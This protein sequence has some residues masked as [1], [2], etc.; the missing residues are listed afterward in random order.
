MADS[1]TIYAL[2]EEGRVVYVGR[3][4]HTAQVRWKAH[5]NP[6]SGKFAGRNV[7]PLT[8][9][10]NLSLPQANHAEREL[11]HRGRKRGWP[12]E[13]RSPGGTGVHTTRQVPLSRYGK[14]RKSAKRAVKRVSASGTVFHEV[15]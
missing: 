3:T 14:S 13:N 8:L 4:R 1:F 12:L 11:I 15:I 10:T 7:E 9:I 5:V 6:K 2:L